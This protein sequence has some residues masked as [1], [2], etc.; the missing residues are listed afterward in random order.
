MESGS[1]GAQL[2]P[3]IF[4]ST[5]SSFRGKTAEEEGDGESDREEDLSDS[6]TDDKWNRSSSSPLSSEKR[7]PL[8]ST[9]TPL[10]IAVT[11]FHFLVLCRV[12]LTGSESASRV[13]SRTETGQFEKKKK[14][15][16]G[17]IG[18]AK[19]QEQAGSSV[20]Y[21][22]LAMSRLDGS[23]TESID[24]S[25]R[26][27]SSG[28]GS[29]SSSSS[30]SIV[31]V[32]SPHPHPHPHSQTAHHQGTGYGGVDP[33]MKAVSADNAAHNKAAALPA[34]SASAQP[35]ERERE[36]EEAMGVGVGVDGVPLGIFSDPETKKIWLYTDRALYQVMCCAVHFISL[37]PLVY[38]FLPSPALCT[39]DDSRTL[40]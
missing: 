8:S 1:S 30:S 36:R 35:R 38:L 18:E 23:L 24:L 37:P 22:L 27:P 7:R 31:K 5:T 39:M 4:P 15:E 28:S 25:S 19:R 10:S 2:M 14:A 6:S 32:K 9:S 21:Y 12:R 17:K 11:D 16:R 33:K 20:G 13:P 3:Y 26:T 34:A 40:I 29:S